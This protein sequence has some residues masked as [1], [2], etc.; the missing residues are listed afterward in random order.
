MKLEKINH[1]LTALSIMTPRQRR[2]FFEL[3]TAEQLRI[4]EE[5]FLNLLKNPVGISKRDLATAKKYKNYIQKL[6][7]A[8]I[9]RTKKRLILNQKGGFLTALIPILGSLL[10]AFLPK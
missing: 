5:L 7:S 10:G 8:E 3:A 6:A 2:A 9:P 4:M 1:L